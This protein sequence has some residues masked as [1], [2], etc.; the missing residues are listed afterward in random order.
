MKKAIFTI[1]I[2][3]ITIFSYSITKAEFLDIER[4]LEKQAAKFH[5][6]ITHKA[7]KMQKAT[8]E[9]Q[10]GDTKIFWKWDL[11]VMPPTWVQSPSTCRT[12][13]EHCYL[14]VADEDW[15]IHMDEADVQVVMNYL[16]EQTMNSNEYGAI[17]MDID[18]FGEIPDEL[19][20]DPKL[21][22]FYSALGSFGGSVFDGYFSVYNQVTEEEA[23]NLNPPGV[24]FT[25][26]KTRKLLC[27]M[28]AL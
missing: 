24:L 19:D 3:F 7:H 17:E 20:N 27:P 6:N 8:T 1:L 11:S 9:Y 5:N 18:N 12:V 16:E 21:I 25:T 2:L 26:Y 4:N 28:T 23:H 15:Q 22:V 10:V 14:F 13:G